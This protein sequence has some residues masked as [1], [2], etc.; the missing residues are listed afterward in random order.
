VLLPTW[1]KFARE[2]EK[3][4]EDRAIFVI[5]QVSALAG[6]PWQSR[7]KRNPERNEKEQ[8]VQ[9]SLGWG[10]NPATNK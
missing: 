3:S 7:R 6:L 9:K 8:S 4:G 10:M 1:G 2:A 5:E